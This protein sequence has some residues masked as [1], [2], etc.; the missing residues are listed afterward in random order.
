MAQSD[1][2]AIVFDEAELKAVRDAISVL[3]RI[4]LPKLKTLS[5]DDRHELP[6]MGD[7]SVAFVTKSFEYGGKHADLRPPYLDMQA[8]AIDVEAVRI[9][10]D[11]E[12][13]LTPVMAALGDSLLLSGSEAYQAALVFYN[14]VKNA[15]KLRLPGAQAIYD[16]LSA[17]FPGFAGA[18]KAAT[19]RA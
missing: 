3:N 9:L 8:F 11:L 16:D 18:A 13:L 6:K 10:R 7:K 19:A 4:L 15:V 5:S 12:Q 2:I 17:R 14:A 1:N